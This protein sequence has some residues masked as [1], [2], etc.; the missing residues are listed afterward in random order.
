MNASITLEGWQTEWLLRGALAAVDRRDYSEV[1]RSVRWTV[2]EKWTCVVA[3]DRYRVHQLRVPTPPGTSTGAFTMSRSQAS[4]LLSSW[5]TPRREFRGQVVTLLWTDP[6]PIP[7]G[8]RA[9]VVAQM[10]TQRAYAGTVEFRILAS[11]APDADEVSHIGLQTVGKYPDVVGLFDKVDGA[12]TV[13]S[14]L[15]TPEYLA[16][17]RWLRSGR[18]ALRFFTPCD[19]KDRG[20]PVMLVE[21]TEGTARAL[22]APLPDAVAGPNEKRWADA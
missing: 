13:P 21:N 5:H 3:T 22:I 1:L 11:D 7:V 4:R 16:D 15:L 18:G 19:P 10:L 2:D 17:T 9:P 6:T 14:A 20:K 8:T 12:E